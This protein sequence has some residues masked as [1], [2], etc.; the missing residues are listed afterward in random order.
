MTMMITKFHKLIQNKVLWLV[1]LVMVILSFVVW[2]TYTPSNDDARR[3][4]APGELNGEPIDR[5]VYD[6]TRFGE[7]VSVVLG[8]GRPIP[9]TPEVREELAPLTWRRY[10][11]LQTA[12]DLDLM[13]SDREVVQSLKDQPIF[14]AEGGFDRKAYENFVRGYL[15]N[16]LQVN[17]P[18]PFF[19]E[20]VRKQLSMAK[21]QH[22]L[23]QTVLVS[24]LDVEKGLT[25]LSDS[26]QA[27]YTVVRPS[28]IEVPEV[29]R[30]Q[31]T[32][33]FEEDPAAFTIPPKVKVK[34]VAFTADEYK[35]GITLDPVDV[36]AYYNDNI[37]DYLVDTTNDVAAADTNL[38]AAASPT[39]AAG[40]AAGQTTFTPFEEV[41]EDIEHL[42]LKEQALEAALNSA[43]DFVY[44]L[45]PDRE[46]AAPEFETFATEQQRTILELDPF[47]QTDILPELGIASAEFV[48]QAFLLLPNKEEYIS[49]P[50][51]GDDAV[52][53]LAL[54]EQIPERI[55]AFEEVEADVTRA[56][57]SRARLEALEARAAAVQE[58]VFSAGAEG[59][60]MMEALEG[61]DLAIVEIGPF[62]VSEGL[63]DDPYADYIRNEMSALNTGEVSEPVPVHDGIL[64][65]QVLERT[66][67]ES[68]A[69]GSLADR[70]ASSL[71]DEFAAR[72]FPSWQD[73]LLAD[74]DFKD[75]D[76]ARKA[77]LEKELAEEE[78]EEE[79]PVE[80]DEAT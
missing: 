13:A 71:A 16:L 60:P 7:Y 36:E 10:I 30:E 19:E 73:Q 12:A 55:P 54:A 50:V 47:L 25:L 41:R 49:N 11:T 62:S 57:Q 23:R 34:Y 39:N 15:G 26:F 56:A 44:E 33:Y 31:A 46:G 14:N 53:V 70:V 64:V 48:E 2:G 51:S 67:A 61:E 80:P 77:E 21:L 58:A 68:L 74:A 59:R 40:E 69:L 63:Q 42:L 1:F 66:P 29:S 8:A 22:M 72:L 28:D 45:M 35:D 24:P 5:Q 52:Y 37:S 65:A 27:A 79:S 43:G 18:L 32:A 75:L 3:A 76:A 6:E 38:L 4:N 17:V 9:M 78:E 20:H